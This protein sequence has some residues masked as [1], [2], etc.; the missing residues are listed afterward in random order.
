M[1]DLAIPPLNTSTGY[2]RTIKNHTNESSTVIPYRNRKRSNLNQVFP[3]INKNNNNNNNSHDSLPSPPL[4]KRQS[5]TPIQSSFEHHHTISYARPKSAVPPSIRE[6]NAFYTVRNSST[7]YIN[8]QQQQQYIALLQILKSQ[9]IQ[10]EQQTTEL[11]ETQ[12]GM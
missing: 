10:L 2:F 11:N 4:Q 9:E 6:T 5:R 7:N 3:L 1:F 12:K 8:M